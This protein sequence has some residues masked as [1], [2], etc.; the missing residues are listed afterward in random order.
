MRKLLCL[1]AGLILLVGCAPK[2]AVYGG[3]GYYEQPPVYYSPP[4]PVYVAPPRPVY[5]VPARQCYWTRPHPHRPAVR[6][7]R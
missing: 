4:P 3:D 7:C 1:C 5:V 2:P 6:V